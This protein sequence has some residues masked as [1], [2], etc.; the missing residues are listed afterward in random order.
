M[1]HRGVSAFRRSTAAAHQRPEAKDG[2]GPGVQAPVAKVDEEVLLGDFFVEV[3][4]GPRVSSGTSCSD[5]SLDEMDATV[6]RMEFVVFDRCTD[7]DDN[8]KGNDL[9]VHGDGEGEGTAEERPGVCSESSSECS[10]ADTSGD[11]VEELPWTR[12]ECDSLDDDVSEE[13]GVIHEKTEVQQEGGKDEEG[14]S[15]RFDDEEESDKEPKPEGDEIISDLPREMGI[16]AEEEGVSCRVDT[17]YQQENSRGEETQDPGDDLSE[18]AHKMEIAAEQACTVEVCKVQEEKVEGRSEEI[19]G[20]EVAERLENVLEE[21]CKEENSADQEANDD[22]TNMQSAGQLEVAEKQEEGESEMEIAE[23]VPEVTCKEDFSEQE[24][25]CRAVSEGEI[26]DSS[27][28]GSPDVEI[29]NEPR[30]GTSFEQD[31]NSVEDAFEQDVNTVEDASEQFDTT[32]ENTASDTED[33]QKG[34]EIATC[35]SVDASEESGISHERSQDFN[36][37]CVDAPVQMEPEI[38]EHKPEDS[39]EESSIPQDSSQNSKSGHVDNGAQVEVSA[40]A[41]AQMIPEVTEC[42]LEESSEESGI[43]QESSQDFNSVCVDAPAKMEPAI[44]ER[45]PEDSSEQ[46][47]IPQ[48]SSQNN[49]SAHVDNGAQ[50]ELSA[51]APAQMVPEITE[52]KLE[53]YSEESGIPQESSQSDKSGLV[54]DGAETEPEFTVCNSEDPYE[55]ESDV[56]QEI[57]HDDIDNSA[58]LGEGV[59]MQLGYVPSELED[60]PESSIAHEIDEDEN[61]AYVSDDAQN[62]SEITTYKL[63]DASESVA[64]QEAGQDH[65]CADVSGGAQNESELT[66]S[67]LVNAS[68]GSDVTQGAGRD[69][70]TADVNDCPKKEPETMACESEPAHGG[71]DITQIGHEDDYPADVLKDTKIMTRKTKDACEEVCITEEVNLSPVVQIPQHNSDLSATEGNGEPE[72]LPAE[73]SDGEPQSLPAEAKDVNDY[74]VDD[75]CSV[76]SGMNLKGDV[77][78]DPTESDI[79]PRKRLIIAGEEENT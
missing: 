36:S 65:S 4:T 6:R 16:V 14:T 46:S 74:S 45:E 8:N 78:V 17:V 27:A 22:E 37:V 60:T 20:S 12:Y 49:K 35:K 39:S 62:G 48:E 47:S 68:E 18:V 32:A 19:S 7:D 53:E 42:K 58:C 64:V 63:D 72:S 26:S 41:P 70:N 38:A 79:S 69:D 23:T 73:D 33:A 50:I 71:L 28:I 59:Q 67:E 34:L 55:E 66:P 57:V 75:M 11:L 54:N 51:D 3:Y 15:G 9:G 52:C 5:M 44:T 77:Y 13:Q 31:V 2:G 61:S 30:N 56:A 43:P 76:F 10:D 29:S 21:I 1:K 25:T 24:S 40:D